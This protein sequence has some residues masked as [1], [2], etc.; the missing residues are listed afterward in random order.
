VT[1]TGH[2][3]TAASRRASDRTAPIGGADVGR[4]GCSP[5]ASSAADAPVDGGPSD[6]LKPRATAQPP[7]ETGGPAGPEPT[8][9]GDWEKGGRC[10]DF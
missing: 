3:D 1:A 2:R 9:Y 5:E 7:G 4:P 10:F 8:R 6:R